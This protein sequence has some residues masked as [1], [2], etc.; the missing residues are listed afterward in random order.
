MSVVVYLQCRRGGLRV[1]GQLKFSRG[2]RPAAGQETEGGVGAHLRIVLIA[3]LPSAHEQRLVT[4]RIPPLA[5]QLFRYGRVY[6]QGTVNHVANCQFWFCGPAKRVSTFFIFLFSFILLS[7]FCFALIYLQVAGSARLL[8]SLSHQDLYL[9][10]R[11]AHYATTGKLKRKNRNRLKFF[12]ARS[13]RN[14]GNS[15]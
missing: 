15:K 1:R 4:F 11:E 5:R 2:G 6:R 7:F 14:P 12:V 10:A 8:V 13:C 3:V 9:Q